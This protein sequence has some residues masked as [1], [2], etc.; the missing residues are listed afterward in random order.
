MPTALDT[1]QRTPRNFSLAV[2]ARLRPQ[3]R[4]SSAGRCADCLIGVDSSE[5]R[6]SLLVALVALAAPALA[7]AST[8]HVVFPPDSGSLFS[9]IAAPGETNQVEASL[10]AGTVTIRDT[11]ASIT[12][13]DG[14]VSVDAHEVTCAVGIH[15][16]LGVALDDLGDSLTL[17]G[18]GVQVITAADGLEALD[19]A[20]TLCPELIL[21]D[22][23][24][25][26][27]GGAEVATVVPGGPSEIGATQGSRIRKRTKRRPRSFRCFSAT[28]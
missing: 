11:G 7:Q 13:G 2:I 9:Y 4:A 16:R 15:D 26:D 22:V 17:E 24:M 28:C 6:L 1:G 20:R 27:G 10:L 18:D 8:A 25:P 14:C 23:H 21:L 12:A 3:R 5:M 19:L